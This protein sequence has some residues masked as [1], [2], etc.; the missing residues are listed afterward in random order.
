MD[1]RA[2]RELIFSLNLKRTDITPVIDCGHGGMNPVTGLYTTPG[3]RS[4]NW[5]GKIP[6]VHGIDI[7]YEGMGN[8]QIGNKT[9]LNLTGLGLS[10]KILNHDWK[11]TSIRYRCD[12]VN[13]YY[14]TKRHFGTSIH[15]NAGGGTG[16]EVFTSPGDTPADPMATISVEMFKIVFPEYADR[17]RSD[18]RDGDP[19]KE[20]SFG[21]LTGTAIPFFLPEAFFMDQK[22]ECQKI[23]M[24]PEGREKIAAWH[25][26]TIIEIIN[27]L[28]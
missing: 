25:T 15:S 21:I 22:D 23:L 3:K 1:I 17:I 13:K 16:I 6:P 28:Y 27:K 18:Y 2:I 19:D 14:N 10:P 8:R 9:V 12:Y 5:T 7:Y 11:D 26:L 24:D 20:E 4:Q